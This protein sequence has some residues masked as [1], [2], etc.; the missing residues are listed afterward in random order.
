MLTGGVQGECDGCGWSGSPPGA[1]GERCVSLLSDGA[2]EWTRL[3]VEALVLELN[4]KKH[5]GASYL[6][7]VCWVLSIVT[8]AWGEFAG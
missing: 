4:K 2:A 6:Y 5:F 1:G 3:G 7:F 8:V